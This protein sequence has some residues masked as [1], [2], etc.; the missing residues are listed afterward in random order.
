MVAFS[1]YTDRSI[2]FGPHG[3]SPAQLTIAVAS[4]TFAI[5]V[6]FLLLSAYDRR[7]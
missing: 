1:C 3:L 4:A 6:V 5:L 7:K 2:A